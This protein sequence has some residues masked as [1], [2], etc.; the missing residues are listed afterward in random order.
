MRVDVNVYDDIY[1]QEKNDGEELSMEELLY[2]FV[3]GHR[4]KQVKRKR[5]S[6]FGV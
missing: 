1:K 5:V 6:V 4:K 2:S 3:G